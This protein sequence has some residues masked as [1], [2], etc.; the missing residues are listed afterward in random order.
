MVLKS[1]TPLIGIIAL[2]FALLAS[3]APAQPLRVLGADISYWNC[4]TS[5]GGI[6]QANWNTAYTTG[7]RQFVQIRATRGGTTGLSQTSGTPGNPTSV[8]LSERY[9]DS[10]FLQNITRATVAGMI[11]GP[12]HF[13]R[14]DVVGNTGTDEADH[15]IEMAGVFMRPG[16]MM[17][18]YDMEA[19]SGD[20][21]TLAQFAI[22]FSDRIY[23]VMQIRPCIYINGNYSSLVQSATVAR[24]DSL[25]KPVGAAPTVVGPAFPMLWDA[26]YSDN[27]VAGAPL[28]PVQTGSPKF[29]YTTSSGYYGP[30]DDYGNTD[31]WSFWQYAS[32]L[33]IDGF[34]AVD[35]NVDGDVSHGDIE[36][37]RNFLVPA[38]WWS[39]SNGDWSTLTNWNSGQPA[40]TPVT[41][42]DQ[43][44]PYTYTASAMPT[45]RLP[46]AAG[47]GPNS[48]QYDTVILE[49]PSAN[50]IVTLSTGTHNVRKLYMRETLNLVGGSLT[51]NY[52]PAY[53]PDDSA[54]VLHGGP[55][56]AQFSGAVTL[57]NSASF[58]VHTLQVDTNRIF[59]LAGGTLTFNTINLMPHAS[60]PAKILVA[61]DVTIN[62]LSNAMATIAKGGGSGTS[63]SID[64]N[65]GTRAFNVGNGT[66]DIDLSLNVP[67][68]NGALAKTGAGTMQILS[69]NTYAVGTTISAGKLLVNNVTGS[70]TGSGGVTVGSGGTLGGKGIIA[71]AVTVNSGGTISPGMSIGTLTL[72]SAPTFNGTNFMEIDRNGGSPL[73]DKITLTSGTLTYGGTLV[74][75]NA[76]AALIGGEVFTLFSAP[77]FTGAFA[78]TNL[79]ALGSTLN[80]YL[81]SLV[82]NGTLKVNRKPVVN[83]VTFTNTPGQVVQI[84]IASLV[85]SATDADS[86]PLTLAGFDSATTNGITVISNSTYLAYSNSANVADQF[87]Y[88]ISDG[89]GGNTTAA[90]QLVPTAST[91]P[92]ITAQPQG[93]SVKAGSN[94][95]FTV[96]AT[97]TPPAYQ[98]RFN[99]A[100]I[101][102]ATASSYTRVNAQTN[103]VGDY[104]VIVTNIAGTLTSSNATLTVTLP[105]PF[106]FQLI[107]RLPDGRVHLVIGGEPGESIWL[108]RA[109]NFVDWEALTNLLNASGT[110][111]FIDD[112]ATNHG[113]GFYRTR[114]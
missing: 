85:G 62:A 93:L 42:P 92:N 45:A 102:G 91:P 105:I 6:S 109:S 47:S 73:A 30:W 44:T 107:E 3:R 67:I 88:T 27:T 58:T 11:A 13:A 95:T 84:P 52:N 64:L 90:V 96:T 112:G 56:S 71:G 77:A 110:L 69:N 48:G 4:G 89:H 19:T 101:S 100:P 15:H 38:V 94:V 10:R 8:I 36:Y 99:T 29:T 66:N 28:I 16:Y 31:P 53:R 78:A 39:D 22:D 104:S 87:N 43:A 57:S 7:N 114:Q 18:M 32:V 59:T 106:Q 41:P 26:R 46:G 35:A 49:R 1:C 55:I 14:P 23:A 9:D 60:T 76:G 17:P 65:G 111:D 72:N 63:G 2:S 20:N 51:V 97:G 33:S 75:S 103:D 21:N 5:S 108:D 50:I 12:Y 34:N 83:G 80:W 86:D 54:D 24:R 98:W 81:G 37:V 68:S 82:T 79:P 40:P 113:R 74:V 70:G 61:G 25:A